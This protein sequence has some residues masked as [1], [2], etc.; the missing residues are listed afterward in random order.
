MVPHAM[1]V[2]DEAKDTLISVMYDSIYGEHDDMII[3]FYKLIEYCRHQINPVDPFGTDMTI[4]DELAKINER[5]MQLK[6]KFR[7][8]EEKG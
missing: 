1:S 2:D 3:E 7:K 5:H 8:E 6:N 4:L